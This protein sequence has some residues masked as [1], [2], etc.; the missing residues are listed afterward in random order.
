MYARFIAIT[1]V[2]PLTIVSFAAVATGLSLDG[3]GAAVA[4]AAGVGAASA[5]WHAVLTLAAGQAGRWIT[6]RVQRG[7][8]IGGRV[9]VLAIAAHLVIG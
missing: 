9:A 2:N 5:A 7:L 1:A 4:F 6:P 8:A 3:A